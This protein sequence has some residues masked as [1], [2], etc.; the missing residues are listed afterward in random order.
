VHERPSRILVS[1]GMPERVFEAAAKNNVQ[2]VNIGATLDSRVL[3][4]NRGS[5]L[6]DCRVNELKNIWNGALEH[7]LHNPVLV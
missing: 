3:V 7:L 6:I 5:V 1:T 2:A 4:R